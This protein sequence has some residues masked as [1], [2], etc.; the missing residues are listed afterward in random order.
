LTSDYS[1][2]EICGSNSR[3]SAKPDKIYCTRGGFIG[4]YKINPKEYGLNM[5]QMEDC[6]TNQLLTLVKVKEAIRGTKYMD[7]KN[8]EN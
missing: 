5:K 3:N 6:D 7:G 8:I 2:R 1:V 4:D